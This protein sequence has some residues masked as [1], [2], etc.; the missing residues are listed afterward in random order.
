MKYWLRVFAPMAGPLAI[1]AFTCMIAKLTPMFWIV[2]SIWLP[3]F[4]LILYLTRPARRHRIARRRVRTAGGHLDP[5]S[6][7]EINE[8]KRMYG[9]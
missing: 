4:A 3:T 2:Q 6:T 8:L 9:E 1:V 7:R 5:L